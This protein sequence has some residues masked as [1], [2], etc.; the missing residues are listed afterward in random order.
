MRVFTPEEV[1]KHTYSKYLG[2]L[3]AAKYARAEAELPEWNEYKTEDAEIVLVGYGI[4]G[5]VL[6]SVVDLARDDGIKA[7]LIRP[8]TLWP[9]PKKP[10]D[11]A[12]GRAERFLV[13]ELSNGQLVDDV[14]L[15][16][17]GRKPVA[18]YGRGGGNV[19]TAGEVYRVMTGKEE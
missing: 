8:I 4:I 14:R 3:V 19:P 5:R 6:R 18:F 15:V 9:F 11:A 10:I 17:N 13:V 7:G 16:V 12:A 2:V 1:A